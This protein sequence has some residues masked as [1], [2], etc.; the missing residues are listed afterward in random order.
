MTTTRASIGVLIVLL[1]VATALRLLALEVEGH[2]GDVRVTAGWA[3]RLAEVG[4][5]RFYEGSGSI[6]PALLYPLWAVGSD[7]DGDALLLAIKGLSIP[8]DI[9]LV[10]PETGRPSTNWRLAGVIDRIVRLPDGRL[11][12]MEYKTTS[13]DFAPNQRRAST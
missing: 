2:N 13:R 8:F 11:A 12:L 10:N 9:A 1:V 7:L 6:Y 3:E 5:W 4:P